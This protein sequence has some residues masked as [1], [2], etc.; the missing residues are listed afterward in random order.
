MTL[1]IPYDL[2][3]PYHLI[4]LNKIKANIEKLLY[5]KNKTSV[6]VLFAVK[7]FSNDKIIPM[8][9]SDFDGI[10]ASGLWEARFG[11][12]LLNKSVHTFSSAYKKED[13]SLIKKYSD[14]IIFNSTSQMNT[15]VSE[16][17][18]STQRFGIRINPEYSE[19]KKFAIN[20]CHQFSRFGVTLEK[21]TDVNLKNISGFH[22]H[23]MCEQY[24][25][26]LDKTLNIVSEKFNEYLCEMKWLN[27]GGGQ[28]YAEENYN[29]EQA[30]S[31]INFIQ[32]KYNLD[33]FLEPCETVVLNAGYTVASVVD[34]VHN[35]ITS[36]I[37]DLSAVC[38]LP[39]IINSPYRCSV[40]NAS[41]PYKKKY[42][43]RLS[44][45]TCYA[46]DIF[47]DYSFDSPLE[48]G[49]KIV[50]LDTAA[51][52]MVKNNYFNGIIPP[53]FVVCDSNNKISIVKEYDYNTFLSIL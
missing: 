14:Y 18:K 43:Y 34:I 38:H 1:D 7:G 27:I 42:T 9:I 24:S 40:L 52:S 13:F 26:T 44:G 30:I 4:D 5:V 6:K 19:V 35:G 50:F 2:K 8:F 31:S 15:F 33:I 10:S 25:M 21:L 20:P 53:Y 29:L 45:C 11:K 36:A 16:F 3:T 48:I 37:L 28:L 23:S 49:S 46:G 17:S 41:L 22:F 32:N 51:Y 12:E 39:D 47:G